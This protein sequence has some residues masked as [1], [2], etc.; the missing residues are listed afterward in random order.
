MT[1]LHAI[2]RP[3]ALATTLATVLLL[4]ACGKQGTELGQGGSVVTGSA[5]PAGNS[6][7]A[8]QL[9]T[10]P[11]PV[12]VVAL[13]ENQGGYVGIGRGGLPESPL[14]LVRVL[15]QQSG[16]F[17]IVDR[18]SGLRSTVREQELK[19]QGVLAADGN[20]QKGSGIMAQYSVVPS[21]TFSEQNAGRQIGG[22]LARIPFLDQ[23][24]GFAEQVKFKEAQ[25][26]L[27]LTDNET[28]EQL[29]SATGAARST[30]LGLGGLF[31]GAGGGAGGL[32]W[33]NTN[34]GKV[35]AA[36]FLDAHNQLVA[37]VQRL[38]A[39]ALPPPVPTRPA[40]G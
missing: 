26:V 18:H 23:F 16:C 21:L 29:L 17:R 37:Q 30:D 22:I 9:A 2:C 19:D 11:A 10:C 27:L 13:T 6:N 35:I 25:V 12:A 39:K 32:G 33:S 31:G 5:G 34:E 28:T 15:M 3:L 40:G 24:A 14:P 38:P 36:A 4:A 20:V 7:A 8:K 1:Q